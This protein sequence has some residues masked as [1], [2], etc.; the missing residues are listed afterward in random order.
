[1]IVFYVF[2]FTGLF[3]L[4]TGREGVCLDNEGNE[5]EWYFIYKLP[6]GYTFAYLDSNNDRNSGQLEIYPYALN[7]DEHPPALIRTLRNLVKPT[8]TGIPNSTVPYFMYND[9]PDNGNPGSNYGHTKGV[10]GVGF[11]A[12]FWLLH[13]TPNFPS[14]SGQPK[15]YFPPGEIEYGQTFLCMT[16]NTADVDTIAGQFLYTTPYVYVNNVPDNIAARYPTLG[17]VFN[18]EWVKPTGTNVASFTIGHTKFTSLAKNGAWDQDI[19]EG[20]V[21]PYLDSPLL[22]ESWIRGDALG[23][24]CKPKYKYDVSDIL[25]CTVKGP[26]GQQSWNEGEDHAKWCIAT[27]GSQRM[28]ICDINRMTTQR[29]R[30]G[31]CVC[32]KDAQLSAQLN[33][34][35]TGANQC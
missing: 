11:N 1:M 15:F 34:S 8:T 33:N 22:V 9:Q 35:I 5:V 14:S 27:D 4:C 29:I 25:N 30:G 17:K 13:S 24:Y 23:K 3:A 31:G 10:M 21:A 2:V 28:C 19:Y 26:S 18:K 12:A 16:I 6:G 32:F 7:D 20:L